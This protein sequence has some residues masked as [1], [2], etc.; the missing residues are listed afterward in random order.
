VIDPQLPRP[1]AP[2][3]ASSA[4]LRRASLLLLVL[5]IGVF[6]VACGDDDS[7][8]EPEATT[9]ASQPETETTETETTA[10]EE[11]PAEE[12]AAADGKALFANNCSICHGAQA[13]GG[14]GGPPITAAD[15]VPDITDQTLKGG[16]GMPAFEGQLTEAQATAIAEY[17]ATL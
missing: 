14:N 10:T 17:V 7:D 13:T 8:D 11:E 12:P 4:W 2:A 3:S 6:T 5:V 1:Q 9:T 15:D 16:G